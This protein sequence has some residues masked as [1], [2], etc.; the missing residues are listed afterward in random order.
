MLIWFKNLLTFFIENKTFIEMLLL[1]LLK[2]AKTFK[3]V[4]N[5]VFRGLYWGGVYQ[6][7]CINV[8]F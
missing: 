7:V 4:S 2:I 8:N 3:N 6:N 5:L 1:R